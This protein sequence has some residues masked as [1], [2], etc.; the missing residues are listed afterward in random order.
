MEHNLD[1]SS[2]GAPSLLLD[3]GQGRLTETP[4]ILRDLDPRAAR[5]DAPSGYSLRSAV[6]VVAVLVIGGA[7]WAGYGALR[8]RGAFSGG[9]PTAV[10]RPIPPATP[11]VSATAPS[12]TH[13]GGQD[14]THQDSGPAVILAHSDGAAADKAVAGKP[15][16][17]D[18]KRQHDAKGMGTRPAVRGHHGNAKP[19]HRNN[20]EKKVVEHEIDIVTAIVK[21]AQSN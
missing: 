5:L 14:A 6:L 15:S 7:A 2:G 3:G 11:G 12:A 10:D 16:S 18:R 9:A 20:E 13:P 19:H 1:R 4:S 21:S 17:P 8:D